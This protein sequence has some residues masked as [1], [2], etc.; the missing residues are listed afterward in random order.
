MNKG[1]CKPHIWFIAEENVWC[2]GLCKAFAFKGKTIKEAWNAGIKWLY[3]G[4]HE[5]I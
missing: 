5:C 3:G 4:N 2:V 1:N